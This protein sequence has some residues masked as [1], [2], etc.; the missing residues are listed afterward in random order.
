MIDISSRFG[1]ATKAREIAAERERFMAA[2]VGFV[3]V[4]T[5]PWSGRQSIEFGSVDIHEIHNGVCRVSKVDDGIET[6]PNLD[7]MLEVWIGD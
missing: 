1:P 6:Y 4:K 3:T 2:T 5:A 7:A